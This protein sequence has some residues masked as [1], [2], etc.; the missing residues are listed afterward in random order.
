MSIKQDVQLCSKL[1][2]KARS[3]VVLSGAG[4]STASGI[5]DF[6]GPEG[7]YSGKNGPTMESIFELESFVENPAVFYDFYR[8]FLSVVDRATPTY[9]HRFLA[10]ME[11][12]SL[13]FGI[14]TQNI[15]ALHQKA[16]SRA[17][18]EIHGSIWTSRCLHCGR[19]Y[20][21]KTSKKMAFSNQTPY[22]SC[23]GLIK[24]DIV[25]FGE[26]VRHL[27]ECMD[28]AKKSDLFLVLGSS[29]TV[30]PASYLPSMCHGTVIIVN[31]GNIPFTSSIV[32][33]K[34][35]LMNYDLDTFFS[36]LNEELKLPIR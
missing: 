10:A 36:T 3:T 22:C 13:L 4:M 12:E 25:F 24:P 14:V 11:R 18:Y 35:L 5:P 19:E 16:G 26:E 20:D 15:D 30:A 27:R 9:T 6:R 31:K 21:Y 28:M 33:P 7:L 34:T 23:R 2:G 8:R 32:G 17:V 29:L 1:M